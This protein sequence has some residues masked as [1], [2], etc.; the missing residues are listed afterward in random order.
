MQKP[1]ETVDGRIARHAL[2]LGGISATQ[3]VGNLL[4]VVIAVRILGPEGYGAFA[5]IVA[6]S[7]IV[8]GLLATPG[9]HT[10]IT[11]VSRSVANAQPDTA[12][13]TIRLV[14]ATSASL[15]LAAYAVICALPLVASG[16]L[17]LDPTQIHAL[18][19][20][21]VVG[22]F[23]STQDASLAVL[24]LAERTSV[25]FVV[26][27]FAASLHV[28]LLGAV[29]L[30]GGGILEVVWAAIIG[31]ATSGVL[32]FVVA[33]SSVG[34]AGATGIFA[35]P[36]LKVAPDIWRFQVGAFGTS[37]ITHIT[38]NIDTLAVAHFAGIT[39]A[40]QYRAARLLVETARAPFVPLARS[41]Q[42]EFSKQ[43]FSASG[44]ALR[45]AARRYT[46]VVACAATLAFGV[47]LG[48]REAL[49]ALIFGGAFASVAPLLLIMAPGSL[50][51]CCFLV[52][53]TL[54]YATGRV[55]PP[56]V[57]QVAALIASLAAL[58][59][60]VPSYQST[61]AALAY[62]TFSLAWCAFLA[63][64]VALIL[65][66]SYDLEVP[67]TVGEECDQGAPKKG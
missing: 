1:S 56:F 27:L 47:L 7:A 45:A 54:P 46:T 40:G 21:G 49:V 53:S 63:P 42:A 32:M 12:G 60:L 15:S 34:R 16:W 10:I 22:I 67:A 28:G 24:R 64:Y 5:V 8:H 44:A 65:K 38:A 23:R 61:G 62:L 11:Y 52:V 17:N 29:W 6:T 2:W 58:L 51:M 26:S 19:W 39:E 13:N 55:T 35:S 18:L 59:V 36:S 14:F 20:F 33:S 30:G 57:A 37:T 3:M 41:V 9:G 43:W 48:F 31:A 50:L 66:G 25:A 4:Q